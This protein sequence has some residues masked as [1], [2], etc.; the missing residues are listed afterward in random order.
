M[1]KSGI[2]VLVTLSHAGTC[3]GSYNNKS[4]RNMSDS[5][6]NH[7]LMLKGKLSWRIII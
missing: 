7:H 3:A 4:Q 6:I 5:H 2:R 1:T